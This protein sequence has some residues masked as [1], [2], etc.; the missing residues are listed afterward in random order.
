MSRLRIG[1]HVGTGLAVLGAVLRI[2]ARDFAW[3]SEYFISGPREDT[4]WAFREA[5]FRDISWVLMA[6]GISMIFVTYCLWA[7]QR[8]LPHPQEPH[9]SA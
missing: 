5:A 3:P 4:V 7:F 9:G 8:A 6:L 2:K 1:L